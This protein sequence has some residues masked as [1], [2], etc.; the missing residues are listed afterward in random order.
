MRIVGLCVAIFMIAGCTP[1]MDAAIAEDYKPRVIAAT[2]VSVTV[3]QH[4]G[5]WGTTAP[6]PATI[7]LA[8]QTCT[9]LGKKNAVHSS[10]THSDEENFLDPEYYRTHQ[11]F[12]C[13]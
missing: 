6:T 11:F 7:A 4:G 8:T 3:S 9:G 13:Q 1:E 2:A 10:F 5:S 12:L